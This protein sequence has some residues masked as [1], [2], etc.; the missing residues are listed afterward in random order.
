MDHELY[1]EEFVD[2]IDVS[3]GYHA[4]YNNYFYLKMPSSKKPGI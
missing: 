2:D 1:D 3:A 4:S